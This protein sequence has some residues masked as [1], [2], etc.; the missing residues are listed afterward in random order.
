MKKYLGETKV[1][2]DKTKYAKYSKKDWTMF[3]IEM[4]GGIDGAHHKDWLIDQIARILKGAKIEIKIAKWD[5]G[6]I[7]ERFNVKYPPKEYWEW[8]AKRNPKRYKENTGNKKGYDG[9]KINYCPW[10]GKKLKEEP[11]DEAD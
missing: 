1:K 9:K 7:E 5:N 6:H 10:C 3:W 4:Y 11:T 2:I 8:V